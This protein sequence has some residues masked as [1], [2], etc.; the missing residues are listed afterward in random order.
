M[1]RE[2]LDAEVERYYERKFPA[3]VSRDQ[4]RTSSIEAPSRTMPIPLHS[5]SGW[6]NKHELKQSTADNRQN[7][8]SCRLR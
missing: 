5:S 8:S 2:K 4:L 1:E 6:A 3:P 7:S